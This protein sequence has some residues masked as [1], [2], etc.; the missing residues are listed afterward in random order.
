[1]DR[2]FKVL[3]GW[4]TKYREQNEQSHVTLLAVR[5]IKI[6]TKRLSEVIKT[7]NKSWEMAQWVKHYTRALEFRSPHPTSVPH[8]RD[9]LPLI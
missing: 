9:T 6:K 1:M 5:E 7:N 4:A 2:Q 8:G 3:I